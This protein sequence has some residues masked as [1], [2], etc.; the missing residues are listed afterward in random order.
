MREPK[1]KNAGLF[2]FDR[3]SGNL[4]VCKFMAKKSVLVE[5]HS[6]H[7]NCR[8]F[9]QHQNF[10]LFLRSISS[11]KSFAKLR[12][13]FESGGLAQHTCNGVNPLPSAPCWWLNPIQLKN[14]LVKLDHFPKVR[15]ENKNMSN[16]H[17]QVIQSD[18]LI[19]KRWRSP[20][21]LGPR[22]FLP[23]PKR[24]RLQNCHHLGSINFHNFFFILHS[25]KQE[26][27]LTHVMLPCCLS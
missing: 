15:G 5:K 22:S 21:T 20:T 13:S 27:G 12:P 3:S 1:T 10:V 23:I 25:L 11:T 6:P 16:H 4:Q 2:G 18:L 17:L 14:M 24:S 26:L 8:A 7:F 19:P 9:H